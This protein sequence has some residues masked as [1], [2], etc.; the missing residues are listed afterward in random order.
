M[1]APSEVLRAA[2]SVARTFPHDR[3]SDG[4]RERFDAASTAVVA[5]RAAEEAQAVLAR[6]DATSA[7]PPA[8]MAAAAAHEVV[9]P[10]HELALHACALEI[11]RLMM[12]VAMF[13]W[14]LAYAQSSPKGEAPAQLRARIERLRQQTDA[15]LR[16]IAELGREG[17]EL[18][19]QV[20]RGR[21]SIAPPLRMAG[22]PMRTHAPLPPD[23]PSRTDVSLRAVAQPLDAGLSTGQLGSAAGGQESTQRAW[24]RRTPGG[25]NEHDGAARTSPAPLATQPLPSPD[26][27]SYNEEDADP[28][29]SNF[30]DD[31][32]DGAETPANVPAGDTAADDTDSW[33]QREQA[34]GTGGLG[35]MLNTDLPR[36]PFPSDE[37]H[38]SFDT[39]SGAGNSRFQLGLP[40]EA[41]GVLQETT[42]GEWQPISKRSRY[43][44]HDSPNPITEVQVLMFW[45]AV[46]HIG[47]AGKLAPAIVT[48]PGKYLDTIPPEM[49]QH[50]S[51]QTL[52]QAASGPIRQKIVCATCAQAHMRPLHAA[53]NTL[54]LVSP[55]AS[56]SVRLRNDAQLKTVTA[57]IF[58]RMLGHGAKK[59]E[60]V[61]LGGKDPKWEVVRLW[62]VNAARLRLRLLTSVRNVGYVEYD[63]NWT[64]FRRELSSRRVLDDPDPVFLRVYEARKRGRAQGTGG[65]DRQPLLVPCHVVTPY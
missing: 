45:W 41:Y 62:F 25:D 44:N 38:A 29:N 53:I 7:A 54:F 47:L 1:P 16:R 40:W 37:A 28:Y 14:R 10:A 46:A 42:S 30:V 4:E 21:E 35:A 60:S 2:L 34:S 58:G 18:C 59:Y 64:A 13:A 17:L 19:K 9:L 49:K 50:Y 31:Y 6:I 20:R 61:S 8:Q 15:N 24:S 56:P 22:V 63:P 33:W 27:G 36:A 51:Y 39:V 43:D 32:D 5:A 23:A 65:A 52:A 26:P 3:R 55:A 11:V 12:G 57:H 48:H